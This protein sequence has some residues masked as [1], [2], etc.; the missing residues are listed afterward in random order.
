MEINARVQSIEAEMRQ[1]STRMR[2]K[3]MPVRDLENFFKPISEQ[4]MHSLSPEIIPPIPAESPFVPPA[5]LTFEHAEMIR[6]DKETMSIKEIAAKWN[7]GETT[8]RDI[9]KFKT[10]KAASITA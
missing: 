9:I 4:N 5:K 7:K 8:I 2:S 6:N 10:F 3:V 1:S